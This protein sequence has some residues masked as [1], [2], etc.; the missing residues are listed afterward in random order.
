MALQ[1]I[2]L[3]TLDWNQMVTAIRP[4]IVPDSQGKWTLHAPVDPGVTLLELFAWLLDQRIY[5]MNQ[6][7]ASLSLAALALLGEAPK[8]A[9]AAV[10]VLQLADA[11]TPARSFPVASAGTIMQLGDA[12]PP[13]IFSVQDDLTVLPVSDIAV[14][15]DGIDRTNDLQQCRTVSL[16]GKTSAE[17][18]IVLSLGAAIPAVAAGQFF[19]LMIELETPAGVFPEWSAQAVAGVPDPAVLTWSYTSASGSKVTAFD[20]SQVHDGTAGLRRAG[21]VRLPLP[22][23]WQPEP[24]G[25][26]PSITAYRI[27]LQ[28]D[29]ATFTYQPQ[30]RR[31]Q[32]NVVLARHRW[33]RSKQPSTK[34]WLP[35]PGN[36]VSLPQAPTDSSLEEFP[37]LEDTVKV[38][39]K[40]SDGVVR[41]WQ[42]VSDLSR[43]C[44]ADRVFVVDRTN[45]EIRFGDGLTGRL[46]VT[47]PND[48]SDITVMFEAGGGPAGNVGEGASWEGVAPTDA[49]PFPQFSAVN[50]APGDGGTES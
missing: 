50:L 13:I 12:N 30:L 19:S 32:S 9:Q 42:G 8:P 38:Q 49:A 11:A 22:G 23:D 35:L 29:S 31:L 1:P 34:S 16:V 44:P 25:A 20:G 7:P 43:Y 39:V 24:Q 4:R 45:Q 28:V 46:P 37:P 18:E 47:S 10:T 2:Q 41:P 15:V 14:R 21:V 6:V 5:W 3:D 33:P 26:D 17:I 40:E 48:E 36:I 27:R